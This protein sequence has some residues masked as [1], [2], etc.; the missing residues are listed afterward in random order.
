M[1]VMQLSNWDMKASRG[2][3]TRFEM[4]GNY[5]YFFNTNIGYI[6][7]RGNGF[8]KSSI[9]DLAE[10]LKRYCVN[11]R[12]YRSRVTVKCNWQRGYNSPSGTDPLS[13]TGLPG[14]NGNMD[15]RLRVPGDNILDFHP[16][17]I[18]RS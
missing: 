6:D 1:R 16:D 15:F 14:L 18:Y 12:N 4:S 3:F 11:E 5:D 13:G 10:A 9:V 2:P 8:T 17:S 7:I